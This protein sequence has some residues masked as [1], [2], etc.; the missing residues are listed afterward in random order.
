MDDGCHAFEE[1]MD[2]QWIVCTLDEFFSVLLFFAFLPL[3][4]DAARM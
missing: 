1:F 4:L 2:G 3:F